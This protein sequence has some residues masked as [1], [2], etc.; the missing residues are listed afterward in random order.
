MPDLPPFPPGFR[1]GVSTAA[2][3]IEGAVAEDGRGP[4]IWDTFAHTAGTTRDGQT[5]DVACDHYHRWEADL[6]LIAGLG[7][8]AYRFSV[9]WSRV[10]P[11]GSGPANPAG[12]DFYERLVDGLLARDIDPLVTL[13][14]WDLPQALQDQGGWANRDT[15]M[16]FGEYAE[17]L[18]ERLGDRVKLWITLNE[19]YI[20]FALGH[21][22]GV[23]APGLQLQSDQ[24][25]VVHHL[26][27][28]HGLAVSALRR[29][30][31]APVTLANN[32]SPVWPKS[33]SEA[34]QTAAAI[35]DL[36]QNH[37]FTDP[38]LLGEYPPGYEFLTTADVD[39]IVMEG[40]LEVISQPIQALG[41]NYY[42]PSLIAAPPEGDPL[43]FARLEIDGYPRT[44]FDWPVVPDGLR[45]LLVGLKDRYGDRLPPVWI[46]ES[47]CSWPGLDDQFRIDYIAGDLR[48]VRAAMD[49]GVEV[50]GYCTWSLMDNF[51]WAEGYHQRFGL[52]HV[53]FD[54]QQRTP[55][56]S[57]E[58]YREVCTAAAPRPDLPQDP[59][60]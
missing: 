28:A 22:Q 46:T 42:N 54:T 37:L 11:T 41:V 35:Y 5:G 7:A 56:R 8:G 52:V 57:Y 4:S 27:L 16:R 31:N 30:S 10:Q 18:G 6:D 15:A 1:F 14:H 59:T 49:A 13:F 34:D 55:R 53:D 21:V 12:L 43:P 40:D 44:A 19:P 24:L 48:A 50:H 58:W 2:Y 17:L 20:H 9:A 23:H 32:H 3:Q 45:E 51:E 33:D 47:G 25:P 29:T 39:S 38:I 60:G 26:L 36:V